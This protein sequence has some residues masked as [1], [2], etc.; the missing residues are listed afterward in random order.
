MTAR[1]LGTRRIYV[2]SALRDGRLAVPRVQ[3]PRG[4]LERRRRGRRARIGARAVQR[5]ARAG[6]AGSDCPVPEA[7]RGKHGIFNVYNQPIDPRNN[8]PTTASQ[9]MAPGQRKPIPT[10]RQPSTIPK[11]G[12]N[13]T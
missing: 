13:G 9:G 2:G 8:M 12:T 10:A 4:R 6:G 3:L 11:S 1:I 7:Y 5:H